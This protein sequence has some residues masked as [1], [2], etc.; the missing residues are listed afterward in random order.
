MGLLFTTKAGFLQLSV[1]LS[2]ISYQSSIP[3]HSTKTQRPT[4][5]KLF[6]IV[7]PTLLAAGVLS[8]AVP[9]P[10]PDVV[11][12]TIIHHDE[13]PVRGAAHG[14]PKHTKPS[15]KDEQLSFKSLK[16]LMLSFVAEHN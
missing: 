3:S 5:M 11:I 14:V 15:I 10:N 16:T 2:N 7:L 13:T 1:F 6:T 9:Q 8:K 12:E 4:D